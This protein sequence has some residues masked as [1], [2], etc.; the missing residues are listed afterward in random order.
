[1]RYR[2]ITLNW[3]R[4]I[5]RKNNLIEHRIVKKWKL[6]RGPSYEKPEIIGPE[7]NQYKMGKDDLYQERD[8][9]KFLRIRG[10]M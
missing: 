6:L 3:D 4:F 5:A 10:Q 1:M 8:R 2:I 9:F 7:K